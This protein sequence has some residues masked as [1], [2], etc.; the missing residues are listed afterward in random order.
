MT[1]LGGFVI[2]KK[3]RRFLIGCKMANLDTQRKEILRTVAE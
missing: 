2:L 3:N 1:A